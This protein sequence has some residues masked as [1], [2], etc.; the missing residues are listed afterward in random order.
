MLPWLYVVAKTFQPRLWEPPMPSV[1]LL[2]SV[3][4]YQQCW[5]NTAQLQEESEN[6][7]Y[8]TPPERWVVQDRFQI[9]SVLGPLYLQQTQ[10]FNETGWHNTD[11]HRGRTGWLVYNLFL[12]GNKKN[13]L[14]ERNYKHTST[15]V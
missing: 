4:L 2:A 6:N 15:Q 11:N 3:L 9:F 14:K 5:L 13:L 7:S 10:G 8:T 1:A 12:K